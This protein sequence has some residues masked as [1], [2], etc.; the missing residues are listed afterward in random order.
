MKQEVNFN[1][2]C[3]SFKTMNRDN[4]FSYEGKK[5]LFDYLEDYEE[6]TGEDVMLDIIAL[7][8]EYTEYEDLKEL[9]KNYNDAKSIEELENHTTVIKIENSDGFIIQNF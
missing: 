8:C 7:C 6:S 5:A 3:D 2:F 4:N 1:E 9:Q